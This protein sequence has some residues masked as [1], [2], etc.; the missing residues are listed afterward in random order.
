MSQSSIQS[1][2]ESD[3]CRLIFGGFTTSTVS[4]GYFQKEFQVRLSSFSL[5]NLQGTK[6][7]FAVSLEAA[8]IEYHIVLI[9]SRSFFRSSQNFLKGFRN[10]SETPLCDAVRIDSLF[11]ISRNY[12]KVNLFFRFLKNLFLG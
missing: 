6:F 2:L 4:S 11:R 5:F 10:T 1:T 3:V 7:F 9:L 12:D 8:Y